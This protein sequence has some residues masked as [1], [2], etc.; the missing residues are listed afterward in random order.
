MLYHAIFIADILAFSALNLVLV[1]IPLLVLFL[2]SPTLKLLLLL[3][4]LIPLEACNIAL[5]QNRLQLIPSTLVLTLFFGIT[6]N[7]YMLYHTGQ[8]F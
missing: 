1:C 5:E 6:D 3:L 2:H 4:L 8:I 7:L